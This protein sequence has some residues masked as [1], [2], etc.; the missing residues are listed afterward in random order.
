LENALDKAL[1]IAKVIHPKI[2]TRLK[3]SEY[4]NSDET[5][6]RVDQRNWQ[7]WT[8]C[9]EKY[10][11]YVADR[12]RSGK[13]IIE[14][15]GEDYIGTIIHD[16]HGAQNNTKA[17]R[18]QHCLPHYDR[19]LKYCIEYENCDW[20]QSMYSFLISARTI[21]DSLWQEGFA[22]TDRQ[23]IIQAFHDALLILMRRPPA[24]IEGMKLY[25]R[26]LK[27]SEKLLTFM[28]SPTIPADN[29]G[30]ERAIRN[31][32]IRQKV[33]GCF[34]N[35]D[36]AKRYAIILSVIETAKKQ[37]LKTLDACQGLFTGNL[38]IA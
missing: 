12:R 4:I 37:G 35:T 19:P 33:S 20:S 28:E 24:G 10:S 21:R 30:A 6:M 14:N 22:A 18:H 23:K 34:R 15:L 25:K 3:E 29:N 2:M 16:C 38:A 8:W 26:V 13:V 5:G 27:H 7:L 11:Y 36:A 32:K 17:G 1:T 31:A 9:N